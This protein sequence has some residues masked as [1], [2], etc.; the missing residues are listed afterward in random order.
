MKHMRLCLAAGIAAL[1]L[2][3]AAALAEDVWVKT[4][5][6]TVRAGKGPIYDG[7]ADV[8]KGDKL[9]VIA[10][11]GTWIKVSVN[12]KEGYIADKLVSAQSVSAE[13][14]PFAG[15]AN[16][17]S[18]TEGAAGRGLRDGA[19]QYAKG[20]NLSDAWMKW[21][22]QFRDGLRAHPQEWEAFMQEGKVGSYA[23]P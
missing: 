2:S 21:L 20:K 3:A 1:T 6:A 12:G 22:E 16:T 10:R 5:L 13:F 17:A 15:A 8:H 14:K 19:T 4:A 11:E 23:T 7:V 18:V 9:T